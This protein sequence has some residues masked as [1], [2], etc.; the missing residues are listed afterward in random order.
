MTSSFEDV[1]AMLMRRGATREQ[2]K[3]IM[4]DVYKVPM[5]G[6]QNPNPKSRIRERQYQMAK[7]AI[8]RAKEYGRQN[9]ET[10]M[11]HRE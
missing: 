1:I 6:C 7:W 9:A 10:T 3:T 4:V 2:A 5:S 8:E 11:G